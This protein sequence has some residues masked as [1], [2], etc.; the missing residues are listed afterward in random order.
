MMIG[1]NVYGYDQATLIS[2]SKN[3]NNLINSYEIP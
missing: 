2:K 1:T 3:K